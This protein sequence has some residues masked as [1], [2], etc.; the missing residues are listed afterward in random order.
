MSDEELDA[1]NHRRN[2]D[3]VGAWIQAPLSED[4]FTA[5][6]RQ[7]GEANALRAENE[8]LR[9]A[10]LECVNNVKLECQEKLGLRL[11]TERLRAEN[12]ELRRLLK[13]ADVRLCDD[14][15]IYKETSYYNS[16]CYSCGKDEES[17]KRAIDAAIAKGAGPCSAT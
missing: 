12:A 3:Y 17:H 2:R 9:Q 4:D 6:I 10:A 16:H 8:H 1:I 15:G 5:L 11:E 13:E 14:G 7:A